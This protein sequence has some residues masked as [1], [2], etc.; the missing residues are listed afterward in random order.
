MIKDELKQ[1]NLQKIIQFSFVLQKVFKL[2]E[3]PHTELEQLH[4]KFLFPAV[5]KIPQE[6]SCKALPQAE[7]MTDE[8]YSDKMSEELGHKHLS[9]PPHIL[10]VEI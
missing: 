9:S 6:D 3:E 8:D 2:L 5:D 7:C 4:Y 10:S 1:E